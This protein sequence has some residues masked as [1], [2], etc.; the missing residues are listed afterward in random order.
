MR[1]NITTSWSS[2]SALGLEKIFCY[3]GKCVVGVEWIKSI[4][5]KV[6]SLKNSEKAVPINMYMSMYLVQ[7]TLHVCEKLKSYVTWDS[8][9]RNLNLQN[10]IVGNLFAHIWVANNGFDILWTIHTYLIPEKQKCLQKRKNIGYKKKSFLF[11][12]SSILLIQFFLTPEFSFLS[13]EN[14]RILIKKNYIF[15]F[16]IYEY[17]CEGKQWKLQYLFLSNMFRPV[18]SQNFLFMPPLYSLVTCLLWCMEIWGSH[19]LGWNRFHRSRKY[20][21]N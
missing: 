1:L 19:S 6:N 7:S 16:F 12:I 10:I 4:V 21:L 17:I 8:S 9:I 15:F 2:W 20:L 3:K 13:W 11:L 5:F 14:Y 18:S